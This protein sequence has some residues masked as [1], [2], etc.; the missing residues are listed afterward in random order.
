MSASA[1]VVWDERLIA[2]NFGSQHPL[3][4]VRVKLTIELARAFGVLDAPNVIVHVPEAAS[5]SKPPATVSGIRFTAASCQ[6]ICRYT[7]PFMDAAERSKLRDALTRELICGDTNTPRESVVRNAERLAAGDPDT[8]LGFTFS[9]LTAQSVL[10]DV[11]TVCG[12]SS[13]LAE[14]SGPGVIDVERTLDALALVGER[15]RKAA[16]DKERVLLATGHP[17]GL[18][19]TYMCVARRL[20]ASGCELLTPLSNERL[21][22]S[23]R[24]KGN[25]VRYLDSVAAFS[26]GAHLYHSHESWPMEALLEAVEAPSLV[27]ADH[28]FAGAA[29]VRGI[30]TV[31]FADVNDPALSVAKSR[32]LTEIVVPLDDNREPERYDVMSAFLAAASSA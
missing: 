24:G 21:R 20:S 3:Q 8:S 22:H 6:R 17:T 7:P 19:P 18:M 10:D 15:L 28:G 23:D 31:A 16:R 27:I 32:G 1:A 26:D 5:T 12:C 13:D 25:R 11:A 9:S 29:I 4:P 14:R 30:E 2:Y